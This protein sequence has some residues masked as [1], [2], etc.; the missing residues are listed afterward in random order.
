MISHGFPNDFPLF[1]MISHG[2]SWFLFPLTW[3]FCTCWARRRFRG[4]LGCAA[5]ASAWH[6]AATAWMAGASMAIGAPLHWREEECEENGH[7]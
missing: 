4:W 1:P 6:G 2:F 5:A 3:N 7:L